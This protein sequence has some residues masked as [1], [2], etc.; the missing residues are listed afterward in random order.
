MWPSPKEKVLTTVFS[1]SIHCTAKPLL[2]LFFNISCASCRF[3][4]CFVVFV[5]FDSGVLPLKSV[6]N[7]H[8]HD[9]NGIMCSGTLA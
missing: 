2:F 4:L 8:M 5:I 3:M 6:C 9:F 7:Q 1:H